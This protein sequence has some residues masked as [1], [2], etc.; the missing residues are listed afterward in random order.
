MFYHS[1]RKVNRI[2]S[3]YHE[4]CC[5]HHGNGDVSLTHGF[6]LLWI[7]I[8]KRDCFISHIHSIF[9]CWNH[10]NSVSHR[11]SRDVHHHKWHI[12]C[13]LSTHSGQFPLTSVVQVCI[14]LT[15]I[16]H[17]SFVSMELHCWWVFVCLQV[18]YLVLIGLNNQVQRTHPLI[19]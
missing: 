12:M 7:H 2:S 13:S 5:T 14:S 10:C 18:I 3:G 9:S 1:T 17:S 19:Q 16:V 4:H 15:L 6:H 11:G 8:R